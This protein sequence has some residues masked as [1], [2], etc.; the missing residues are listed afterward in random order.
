MVIS[1]RMNEAL[2]NN[3]NT[4]FIIIVCLYVVFLFFVLFSQSIEHPPN[5]P[6]SILLFVCT[7]LFVS[8]LYIAE[9]LMFYLMTRE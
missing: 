4:I 5:M 8:P 9:C 2:V 1:G 7:R 6:V 3:D